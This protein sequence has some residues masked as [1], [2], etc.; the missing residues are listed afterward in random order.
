MRRSEPYWSECGRENCG[1]PTGTSARVGFCAAVHEMRAALGEDAEQP[2]TGTRSQPLTDVLCL[3]AGPPEY[4]P[5]ES[6][7]LHLFSRC[8][9]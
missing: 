5:S 8:L 4:Q 9:R 1:W 2:P 6:D 3:T 7:R